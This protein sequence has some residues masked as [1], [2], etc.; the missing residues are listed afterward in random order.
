VESVRRRVF[1]HLDASQV[2]AMA[3]IFTSIAIAL[4][5]S[6]TDADGSAD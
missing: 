4:T 1:D 3:S 2:A 5:A 6:E